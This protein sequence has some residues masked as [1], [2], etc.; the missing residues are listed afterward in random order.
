VLC[1]ATSLLCVTSDVRAQTASPRPTI[2]VAFGGGSARG[3]AHIGVIR[4]FEEHRIPID[5]AAG[6]S[7]GA[8]VGGA[9]A[10]GMTAHELS[11]MIEETD[12]DAM[13]GSSSFPFKNIRRKEDA[14]S[15]PSRLEFGL[16]RGIVPPTALNDGQQVDL[17]LARIA[18]PYYGL[19]EFDDLPT[20][21][22]TVAVDLLKGEKVVIHAGSLAQAMRAS[23]SL[24]GVFPPVQDG[25]RVLVDGGALDNIPADVVRDMG[26]TVVIA[27]SVGYTAKK[28][29]DYSLFALMGQTVDAMMEA[30]T[31]QALTAA[32]LLIPVDV[33]GFGSLDW[34]RSG[35]LIERG[36]EAADR[37]S[38]TLLK[39]AA[40]E[41][42]WQAWL[43]HRA[44]RRRTE[45]PSP[46][47]LSTDGLTP[48]DAG[49]T[50][51]TL[52]MHIGQAVD[53]PRLEKDL[54]S[55]SG[56]DRY[57]GLNWQLVGP[58]GREGLLVRAHEKPYAPPFLMLGVNVENTTSN[59]FRVQVAGRYLAFDV[60][61][62]GAELRLDGVI[63]T[64]PSLAVA[65]YRPVRGSRFF[66]RP[67]AGFEKHTTD[68][69]S[70]DQVVAVYRERRLLTEGD[71]GVTLSRVSELFGGLRVGR[72]D[73]DVQAGSPGLPELGGLEAQLRVGWLYDGQ[74]SPVIPSHGVRVRAIALH[75]LQSPDV[76][77]AS[78]TNDGVSQA[79]GSFSVF[80]TQKR[81]NRVFLMANGG[82]SFDGHPLPTAQFT[83]GYPFTLDAFSVGERRGD[84][85]GVATLGA[86][87]RVGR[88]PDFLG[89]SIFAGLWLENGATFDAVD[90]LHVNTHTGFGVVLD[91]L[92]GPVIA[93]AGLGLNGGWRSFV[94]VGRVFR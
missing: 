51:R 36:Y 82:T 71:V 60:G 48:A 15:Y 46:Q 56:L 9:F 55:L 44:H 18:A 31:R 29:I 7:M 88:L 54:A 33:D 52:T 62:S 11:V 8:L 73:A 26:A 72:L 53:I 94:G 16:K 35:E 25:D 37:A 74:D 77:G 17:L 92:I 61:G 19:S 22:R 40:S 34:R 76:S 49:L 4:W 21:F 57:E 20:P 91:T 80:W 28:T 42:E 67:L 89:G 66:V 63:G 90:R 65:W 45:L 38:A 69:T 87:R 83:V 10:S 93:G 64:D 5:V 81:R 24:P 47:F 1:L 59:D 23:M 43:A 32:D 70:G 85:F 30:G 6:T 39:Y 78:R 86:L 84:H 14:R 3:L 41:P 75:Y 27:V 79:E 2:G 58:P 68:F 12:W 13:F 50:R